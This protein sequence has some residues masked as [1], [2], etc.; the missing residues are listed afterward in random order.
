MRD[1]PAIEDPLCRVA[2]RGRVVR[3]WGVRAQAPAGAAERAG[4]RRGVRAGV[5]VVPRGGRGR[6]R[7]PGPD[8]LR[9]LAPEAIV[10][11]LTSGRMRV[12]GER[13]TEASAVRSRNS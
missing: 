11:S 8:V 3:D 4:G 1:T 12:Q 2:L 5:R 9:Q 13:L 6:H 7:V 10:T